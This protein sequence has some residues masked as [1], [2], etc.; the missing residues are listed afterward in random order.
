[1]RLIRGLDGRIGTDRKKRHV[2]SGW[3]GGVLGGLLVTNSPLRHWWVGGV[4]L[5]GLFH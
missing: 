3:G 2:K 5:N 1:M 4:K